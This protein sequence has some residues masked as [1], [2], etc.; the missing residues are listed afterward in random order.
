[1]IPLRGGLRLLLCVL[2]MLLL[3]AVAAS[4]AAAE[5]VVVVT[6]DVSGSMVPKVYPEQDKDTWRYTMSP[7][8]LKAVTGAV[9]ELVANGW[10]NLEGV[11]WVLR[12]SV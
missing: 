9:A 7:E 10:P 11:A 2:L 8:Q 6:Y 12:P 3:V 4:P 5:R 1:M